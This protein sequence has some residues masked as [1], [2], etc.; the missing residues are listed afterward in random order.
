[1][2]ERYRAAGRVEKRQIIDEFAEIA[3]CHRKICD[4]STE[5]EPEYRCD[6]ITVPPANLQRSSDH[7]AHDCLGSGR[8]NLWKA[9]E[10]RSADVR[11]IY[12]HHGHL[13]LDSEVRQRLLGMSAA[14]IDRLFA[15]DS[16][17][18][19]AT[20]AK[21]ISQHTA[22]ESIGIR[23]FNNWNNPPPRLF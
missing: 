8:P 12:D 2:G 14:T 10:G 6:A 3:E 9:T 1:M 13:C 16:R 17:S 7:G 4:S 18:C 23:T 15:S 21:S 19:Q 5:R 11:G 20:E 22:S